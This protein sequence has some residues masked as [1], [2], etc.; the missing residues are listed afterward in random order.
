MQFYHFVAPL[1]LNN[2]RSLIEKVSSVEGV[3]G[4]GRGAYG[5]GYSVRG[6]EGMVMA[7]V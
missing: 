5:D 7:I 1:T 2:G 4:M 3:A 6:G